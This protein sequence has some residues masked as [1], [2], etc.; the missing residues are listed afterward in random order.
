MEATV[1]AVA[2]STSLIKQFTW[3]IPH[4]LKMPTTLLRIIVPKLARV[5]SYRMVSIQSQQFFVIPPPTLV[6]L[7][8][9]IYECLPGYIPPSRNRFL[10]T[11][12]AIVAPVAFFVNIASTPTLY[13]EH[14]CKSRST[15]HRP[16]VSLVFFWQ[17]CTY[18]LLDPRLANKA[19]SNK[20]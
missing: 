10:N 2:T 6:D 4:A 12:F 18:S 9:L 16:P 11:L 8:S 5:M 17:F 13:H 20:T 19:D 7:R 14:R 3:I 1:N 15:P